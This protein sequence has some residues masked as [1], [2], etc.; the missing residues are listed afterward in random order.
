MNNTTLQLK[1]KERLNKL[2]SNDNAN[3]ECW[4]IVEAFNKAQVEWVRKQ[5]HGNNI[6]KEG[7]E[8]SIRRIGDLQ[9]LLTEIPLSLTDRGNYYE[10][11]S[12]PS[13]FMEYNRISINAYN[14]CCPESRR[15]TVYLAEEA[16]GDELLIDIHKRPSFEWGETFATFLSNTIRIYTNNEFELRDGRL[17]Y[18]RLP[19]RIQILDCSDPY[20][21]A[22]STTDVECEFKD[23]VTE[24]LIDATASILAGDMESI[25]QFEITKSRE[26]DNN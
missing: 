23:D 7:S 17:I 8:Q 3:I 18:Y 9:P 12:L 16:N 10:A 20:T 14:E 15:M 1:I 11:S 19:R 13:D 4:L 26:T 21:L 22:I 25:N 24:L 6:F 5:L 2:A